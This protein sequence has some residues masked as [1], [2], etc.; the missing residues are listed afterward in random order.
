MKHFNRFSLG[1]LLAGLLSSLM[2][3]GCA[4]RDVGNLSTVM[5]STGVPT[6]LNRK[7][8]AR[9]Y[10][11]EEAGWFEERIPFFECP[12][13]DLQQT[14][15]FRWDVFRKHLKQTPDGFVVT[16]FTPPVSWAGKYNTISCAAGHHLYEGRWLRETNLVRDYATFWFRK[17]GEPRKYSFWAADAIY[18]AYRVQHERDWVVDLLPDLINNFSGWEKTRRD[19]NGLFWQHDG[20]DGMEVSIGGSGYRAT[21]NSYM[22][23]DA[24]AIM[25]IAELAGDK[26][27]A[28]RFRND[29]AKIK[30]LTQSKLWDEEAAFFKVLPRGEG[31]S[32][33]DVRELHGYTPWYF[34]LP[35]ARFSVAWT[36]F[37]DP[38]GF[39]APF[40]PTTAERRHPRFRF[41]HEQHC[42]WNGPSWPYST[43]V[44]LTAMA[45]L[46]NRYQQDYVT[47][48]D[49][50]E[51]LQIYARSQRITLPD[52]KVVPWIDENLDGETGEWITR[53]LLEKRGIKD[54]GKDYNHSSF[55]DLVITGLV[56]LRP[57]ADNMIE[58]NPLV[59]EGT[60]DWFC[61][62]RVP[63]HGRN[64]T[65]LWDKTGKKYGRGAGLR[66]CVDGKKVA[67]APSLRRLTAKLR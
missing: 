61:L 64:L 24:I 7:L 11:G 1:L 38:Q 27:T 26:G 51:M 21:I 57:R 40:G 62:D 32:P 50:F 46:L 6:I 33:A 22:F 23:G 20:Q 9:E 60:W 47:K 43:A 28:A 54:R 8:L 41:P 30:Q 49:Y 52:G 34:N 17:G 59:P 2:I 48:Q 67:S 65:I 53:K 4:S 18:A 35:D 3:F 39:Y 63:Y 37:M 31:K 15:Y 66:I 58:V 42:L 19:D 13:A 55:C 5:E 16:E 36:Q 44:T 12:D 56:G 29:A 25:K 14:Y 10:Y 45:N